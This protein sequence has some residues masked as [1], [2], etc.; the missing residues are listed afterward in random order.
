MREATRE[1]GLL[2]SR[3]PFRAEVFGF[4]ADHFVEFATILV[5]NTNRHLPF[6]NSAGSLAWIKNPRLG[7]RQLFWRD[8]RISSMKSGEGMMAIK[9][10]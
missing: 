5:P 3:N 4:V 7:S 9:T 6:R 8:L 2:G 10:T 1:G